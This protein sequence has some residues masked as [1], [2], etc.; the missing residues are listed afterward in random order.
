[1]PTKVIMP[2]LGES[3]V[4]GTLTRWLKAPGEPVE[5][6]EP[7][8]E[9]NTDKVD[10]E[11]PSPVSGVLLEVL[12]PA[13]TLVHA[14]ELLALIGSPDESAGSGA[15]EPAVGQAAAQASPAAAPE[16]PAAGQ[17]A[18]LVE[19]GRSR[20]LGFI[21]PVV[22]RMAA[23]HAIDLF[24]VPGTGQAG[25]ITKRDIERYLEQQAALPSAAPP[26]AVQPAAAAQPAPAASAPAA[27][28]APASAAAPA[29]FP[30]E[31]EILPL[32]TVRRSIAEHMV[33]SKHTSPHVTTIMEADLSRVAAHRQANKAAFGRDG[34]NLTFTAYFM[35]AAAAALKA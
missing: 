27:P 6:H 10:T 9:V 18:P 17:A 21:S 8:V 16:G 4:E 12:A 3:V 7:L 31:G 26:A 23:E 24:R 1:M 20:E 28:A 35:G 30:G 19:A 32:T 5:Q 13:G 11:V 22:A 25:R 33:H 15:A 34:A 2:S 14:G 29:A